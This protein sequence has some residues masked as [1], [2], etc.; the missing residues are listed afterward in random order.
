MKLLKLMGIC[1]LEFI[2]LF[3]IGS[4]IADSMNPT[5]WGIEGRRVAMV[6]YCGMAFMTLVFVFE[7]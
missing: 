4:F 5:D 3:F 7:P 1:F 6:I 2:V